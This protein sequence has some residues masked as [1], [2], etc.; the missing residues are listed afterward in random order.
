M[1]LLGLHL[2]IARKLADDLGDAS[3]DNERGAYYLGATT[4]DIRVLTRRDREETHFFRL[5]DFGPQSGVKRM[6]AEHPALL[7]RS[8]LDSVTGAFMAGYVTHLVLDEDYICDIYRPFFGM[9]SEVAD[10]VL[11]N[12]MDRM[13]QMHLDRERRPDV[14]SVSDIR[15]ALESASVNVA[16]DFIAQ[17]PLQEWRGVQLEFLARPPQFERLLRRYLTAVGVEGEEAISTWLEE[18]SDKLLRGTLDRIGEERIREYM[19]DTQRHAAVALKEY[20]S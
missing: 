18:N 11:A 17:Q 16:V 15:C 13:L 10:D 20:L 9:N 19:S 2:T 6:F 12:V 5:E 3:I 1:P 4:P 14:E 8:R 7:D